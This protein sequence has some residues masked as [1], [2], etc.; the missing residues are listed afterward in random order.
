TT[1]PA[2]PVI[3]T[4]LAG[5]AGTMTPITVNAEPNSKVELFDKNGQKIGEGNANAQGNVTITPTKPLPEGNVTAKA[6][7]RAERPNTSQPSEPKK[8]TDT[9]APNKPVIQTDLAGKAGTTTPVTVQA[10][11]NSKVELFDKDGN[12]IGEGNANEQGNVTIT[13]TKP[14]PEGNVTAKAT[15]RAETPNTSQPSEP[16]KATDT[17]APAKPVIQTDLAGKAGTTTP[18]TVQAE[19]NSKVELFDKDG[20]KIGEGNANAQGKAVITPTKPLPE[21]NVTAKATDRAERP[22]TSQ[23]SDPKKA[24]D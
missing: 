21:G 17:T 3:Q 23:P 24:T 10:E 19:P 7:D 9:T 20:N 18:V 13:P 14:L 11:P 4:D 16:K 15:D 1:A 12:K 22:N 6:T 8:A 5:K 2:K